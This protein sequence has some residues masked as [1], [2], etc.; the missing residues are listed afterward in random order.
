MVATRECSAS[1]VAGSIGAGGLG[2]VIAMF[3]FAAGPTVTE[4][5]VEHHFRACEAVEVLYSLESCQRKQ[6]P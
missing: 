6:W 2:E 3:G 5:V 4:A 1:G